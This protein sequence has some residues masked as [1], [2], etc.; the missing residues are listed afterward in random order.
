MNNFIKEAYRQQGDFVDPQVPNHAGVTQPNGNQR[1]KNPFIAQHAPN[2][3]PQYSSTS[4][5]LTANHHIATEA[6]ADPSSSSDQDDDNIND[7]EDSS[8]PNETTVHNI[9][10]PE[11]APFTSIPEAPQ[12]EPSDLS[13]QG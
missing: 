1:N 11:V 6:N 8:I 7:E 13:L 5:Q 2:A 12:Q 4:P 3:Y 9:Q 10:Q